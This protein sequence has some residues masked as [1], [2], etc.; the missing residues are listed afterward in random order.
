MDHLKLKRVRVGE[1]DIESERDCVTK[2]FKRKCAP[3]MTSVIIVEEIVHPEYDVDSN[4]HYNDIALLRLAKIL[5]FT[6]FVK[7]ICLPLKEN[8]I[9]KNINEVSLDITGWGKNKSFFSQINF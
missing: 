2:K 5:D 6:E 4:D 7:P 3:P 8:D 9:P 1:Y